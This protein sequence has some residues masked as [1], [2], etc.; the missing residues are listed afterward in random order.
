MTEPDVSASTLAGP[1]TGAEWN[2]QVYHAVANPHVGWGKALLDRI[3]LRGDETVVDAG[4][5]TGRVTA[6][7]LDRLPHGRVVGV[8]RSANMLEEAGEHL[9]QC[10]PGQVRLVQSDLL[11]IAPDDIGEPA[12][13]VFSTATFQWITDHD[14]LFRR[15]IALLRHGGRLVA[16]C[17][18]GPNL[19]RHVA[20]AETL[21]ASARFADQF[22]GWSAPKFYA[23]AEST[24]DRLTGAGF[25]AVSTV[26]FAAPVVLE[27]FKTFATYL[28]TIVFR[29][30]L[31]QLPTDELRALFIASLAQAAATDDPPF[32]LDY[33]RLDLE[34]RR[35]L[36]HGGSGE[37]GTR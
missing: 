21:M 11:E 9:H 16:Q 37:S 28:S 14:R 15:L 1:G 12:D 27:D 19:Q 22:A 2:A 10:F 24:A 26:L 5:G 8:D 33:W 20:R 18:G 6:D 34:G 4:C 13:I 29:E 7:L 36:E 23:D 25:E 35:P 30:H 3:E 31:Q 17:G 32:L